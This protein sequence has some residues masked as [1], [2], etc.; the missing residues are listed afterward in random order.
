MLGYRITPKTQLLVMSQ[1]QY[2]GEAS[3]N[4]DSLNTP[5]RDLVM[6]GVGGIVTL[7]S[8]WSVQ[9][10]LRSTLWQRTRG[11][12]AEDQLLQRLLLNVGLSWSPEID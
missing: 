9:T 12:Y 7:D 2:D 11:G 4:G 5:G 10:Q 6:G 8:T 1:F 3:W